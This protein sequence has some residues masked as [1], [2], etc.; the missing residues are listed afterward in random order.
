M[1]NNNRAKEIKNILSAQFPAVKFSVRQ[2]R[3][4]E[5]TYYDFNINWS[6]PALDQEICEMI[7]NFPEAEWISII[8]TKKVAA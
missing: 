5:T 7:S 8:P 2:P 1:N 4:H 6:E 3:Q